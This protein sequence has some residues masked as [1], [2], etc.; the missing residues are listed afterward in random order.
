MYTPIYTHTHSP[1]WPARCRGSRRSSSSTARRYVCVCDC[2]CICVLCMCLCVLKR[3]RQQEVR[4]TNKMH[5]VGDISTARTSRSKKAQRMHM[6]RLFTCVCDTPPPT[7]TQIC[8]RPRPKQKPINHPPKNI[9]TEQTHTT[10]QPA[11]PT[12]PGAASAWWPLLSRLRRKWAA[13]RLTAG[14]KYLGG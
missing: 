9:H 1:S 12:G 8:P 13:W 11:P 5:I 2:V 10:Q 7:H 3:Y 6:T 4:H 14:S